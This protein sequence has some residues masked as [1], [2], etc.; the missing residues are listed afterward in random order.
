[1]FVE[2]ILQD[3]GHRCWNPFLGLLVGG[4]VPR[5]T[6]SLP[7][8]PS[9]VSNRAMEPYRG[10]LLVV[11]MIT[12]GCSGSGQGVSLQSDAALNMDT[13][14]AGMRETSTIDDGSSSSDRSGVS[15]GAVGVLAYGIDPRGRWTVKYSDSTSAHDPNCRSLSD[16][17]LVLSES[18]ESG[19]KLCVM[20]WEVVSDH[21]SSHA[22]ITATYRRTST[23]SNPS[24][25]YWHTRVLTVT[26]PV[27]K[28][29]ASGS[30]QYTLRGGSNCEATFTATATR[31]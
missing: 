24:E 12:M 1:M 16:D 5:P 19:A 20:G 10:R 9:R 31:R 21:A 15:C 2:R 23:S 30:L 4:L 25:N 8:R 22:S 7:L 13:S 28:D 27:N 3:S 6:A 26:F 29:Q 11:L 14:D 17:D 18:T